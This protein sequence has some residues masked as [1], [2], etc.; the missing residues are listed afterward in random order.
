MDLE[1]MMEVRSIVPSLANLLKFKRACELG[2]RL[3]ESYESFE[4]RTGVKLDGRPA[5]P[6]EGP[7]G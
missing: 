4:A 5:E 6:A 3:G 7:G 1:K 2:I